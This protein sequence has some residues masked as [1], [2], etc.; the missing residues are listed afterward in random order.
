MFGINLWEFAGTMIRLDYSFY[1]FAMSACFVTFLAITVEHFG[2]W[3]LMG[4][5]TEEVGRG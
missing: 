3:G 1:A 2:S 5:V 4:L